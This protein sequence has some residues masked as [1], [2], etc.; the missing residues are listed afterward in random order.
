MEA[1]ER[2]TLSKAPEWKHLFLFKKKIKQKTR[3]FPSKKKHCIY[4]WLEK[5][6]IL[7][8]IQAKRGPGEKVS[9]FPNTIKV[10][11]ES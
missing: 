5:Y 10:W 4:Q 3:V 7:E 8:R 11:G 6:W 2:E 9:S 1:D